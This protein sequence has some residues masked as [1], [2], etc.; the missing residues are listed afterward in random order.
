MSD[1]YSGVKVITNVDKELIG[2]V[3]SSG[4]V[5]IDQFD[6][7]YNLYA[8]QNMYVV[9]KDE[10]TSEET[11]DVLVA[12]SASVLTRVQGSSLVKLETNGDTVASGIRAKNKEQLMALDALLDDSVHVVSL[13]GIAGTGKTLLTLAAAMHCV[14]QGTYNKI[15][16]TRPMTQVGKHDL[17]ILPGEIN[18][19]FG[20]YLKNY[21]C[22]FE[23]LLKGR[24][25]IEDLIQFYNME[26]VPLQLIRG[27][28][29]ANA[30]IIA[31]EVQTLNHHEMLTLGT[32]IGENSKLV[33]MGDLNQRDERIAKDKTGLFHWV[34]S[35]MVKASKLTASINL[36][37][38]ERS[39]IC[40]L[41]A[42]VFEDV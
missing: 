4:K 8:N 41:F 18:D 37:K 17:G 21:M 29:W 20:P 9:L 14:E 5:D 36:I 6:K 30:F 3:Y 16:L 38:S 42:D 28:S 2:Q 24:K 10:V 32:R 40:K 33:N 23:H 35:P 7:R 31:D 26:F 13:T 19:K 15:I 11:G 22:N 27:A 1:L 34:N 39:E 25:T 12:G